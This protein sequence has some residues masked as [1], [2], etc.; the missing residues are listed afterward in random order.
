MT[1][2]SATIEPLPA[3]ETVTLVEVTP[4]G[5]GELSILDPL[6]DIRGEAVRP[7]MVLVK[8]QE[9]PLKPLV[10]ESMEASLNR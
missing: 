8:V 1:E 4:D 2:S 10:L 6:A 7:L 3:Q 9:A 5:N